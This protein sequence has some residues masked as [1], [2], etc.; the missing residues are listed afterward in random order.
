MN[1]PSTN[2]W[3]FGG[4]QEGS[5]WDVASQMKII[6][7]TRAKLDAVNLQSVQI[8]AMDESILDI[9]VSNWNSYDET[10]KANIGKM[11]THMLRWS[12]SV[13]S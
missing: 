10:T 8:A 5:H 7:T 12:I 4:G 6:N 3:G 9:F 13:L 1:E 2:Y 11:N